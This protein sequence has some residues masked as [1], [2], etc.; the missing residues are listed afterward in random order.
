MTNQ[1]VKRRWILIFAATL[2]TAAVITVGGFSMKRQQTKKQQERKRVTELPLVISH[3]SRLHVENIS[4]KNPG[5]PD[6][7]AVIKIRNDSNL[8]VMAVE[9]ST[10]NDV[11]SAAVN[12]DGLEDSENPHVVIPPNG[13]ITLEMPFTN[14]IPD[15]PLVVSGAVFADRSEDGDK[16][17]LDAMR[18]VRAHYQELR[19]GTK[20]GPRQ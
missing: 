2:I 14:M 19:K 5:T 3:V 12:E 10:K 16:W 17:S 11:D 7:T 9:I 1:I 18:G 15:V 13:T 20:G 4:V 6:A 8:A